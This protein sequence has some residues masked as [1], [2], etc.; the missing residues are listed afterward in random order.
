MNVSFDT[1]LAFYEDCFSYTEE[2][3]VSVL[4]SLTGNEHFEVKE[5]KFGEDY[6]YDHWVCSITVGLGEAKVYIKA[7]FDSRT[8]RQVAAKA[9]GKG[10]E[11]IKTTVLID[12]MR[13]YL[14]QVMGDIKTRYQS[15]EDEV[16]LPQITPSYDKGIGTQ[17][18]LDLNVKYWN[19]AWQQGAIVVGCYVIPTGDVTTL[20]AK[21]KSDVEIDADDCIDFL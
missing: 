4:K 6:T 18:D 8:A 20:S 9:M 1:E 10:P 7:H 2:T 3:S 14:N 17:Q 13:E 11:L 5:F 19:V 21:E 16:S 15:D 12:F